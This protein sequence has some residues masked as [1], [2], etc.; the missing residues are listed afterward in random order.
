MKKLF[1]TPFFFH[2][3]DGN[4]AIGDGVDQI[5]FPL[6]AFLT[7]EPLYSLPAPFIWQI[8]NQGISWSRHT[9]RDE[10]DLPLPYADGDTYISKVAYYLANYPPPPTLDE[11]KA[12]KKI[13]ATNAYFNIITGGIDYTAMG[14]IFSSISYSPNALIDYT[15]N[16]VPPGFQIQDFGSTYR[17]L[18][19]V[20]LLAINTGIVALVYASDANLVSINAAINAAATIPDVEAID[21]TAGYP[22]VPYV[23]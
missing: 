17:M 10:T 19:L 11:V 4:I 18:T 22:T 8:Y 2:S 14:F 6:S 7:F 3:P 23:I 13:D 21:V 16:G 20:Q 1:D 15:A 5:Q 12:A 9:S